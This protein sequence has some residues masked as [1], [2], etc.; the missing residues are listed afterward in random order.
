MAWVVFLEFNSGF[1][2]DIKWVF[3]Y[4]RTYQSTHI[5]VMNNHFLCFNSYYIEL[6][7]WPLIFTVDDHHVLYFLLVIYVTENLLVSKDI[8]KLADFG[9]AREINSL[10]PFTEYVSTRWSV[11][12]L[13]VFSL[14]LLYSFPGIIKCLLHRYRAPE[15][16]LQSPTYGPPVGE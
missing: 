15:V 12:T 8:I 7:T 4:K 11:V 5:N 1:P 13:C 9:L 14:F 3:N 10:P 2:L 16:L 6:F